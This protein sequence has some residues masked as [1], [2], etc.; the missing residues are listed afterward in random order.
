MLACHGCADPRYAAVAMQHA[1]QA[2]I[3][4][5]AAELGPGQASDGAVVTLLNADATAVLKFGEQLA[6]VWVAPFEILGICA[7]IISNAGTPGAVAVLVALVMS[8]VQMALSR[9]NSSLSVAIRTWQ[10][11]LFAITADVVKGMRATKMYAWEAAMMAHITRLRA[12]HIKALARMNVHSEGVSIFSLSLPTACIFSAVF[13]A[14]LAGIHLQP[15]F[16]GTVSLLGQLKSVLLKFSRALIMR[17]D[18]LVSTRKIQTFLTAPTPETGCVI[19]ERAMP[20]SPSMQRQCVA[21][22]TP[23]AG[24]TTAVAVDL[25][26]PPSLDAAPTAWS[27]RSGERDAPAPDVLV[28]A[29]RASCEWF[30]RKPHSAAHSSRRVAAV[31][32]SAVPPIAFSV[33]NVTFSVRRGMVL[34]LGGKSGA[35]K[36]SVLSMLLGDLKPLAGAVLVRGRV[37]FASQAPWLEPFSI[38]DNILFGLPLD[39]EWYATVLKVRGGVDIVQCFGNF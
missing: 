27:K 8:A 35:G 34:G 1:L 24:S 31:S 4:I 38:R 13:T 5:K 22:M 9:G 30:G 20:P 12:L 6:L 26:V 17:A 37:A 3:L 36:S 29:L 18:T 32:P 23:P 7:V 33:R 14:Y 28:A 25:G 21:P 19:R 11:K 15:T 16:F 39:A 2:A 10:G